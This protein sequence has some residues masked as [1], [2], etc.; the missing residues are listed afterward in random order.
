MGERGSLSYFFGVI[1]F[2]YKWRLLISDTICVKFRLLKAVVS[3]ILIVSG[4]YICSTCDWSIA[5]RKLVVTDN[6]VL[7]ESQLL[8]WSLDHWNLVLCCDNL[9]FKGSIH[10]FP[11]NR[12]VTCTRLLFRKLMHLYLCFLWTTVNYP[13]MLS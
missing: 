4:K 3:Q 5:N 13:V 6:S 8:T 1:Q 7:P 10:T 12:K 11:L 9:S 2:S